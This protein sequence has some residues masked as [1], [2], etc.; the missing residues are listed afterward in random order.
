MGSWSYLLSSERNDVMKKLIGVIALLAIVFS[1]GFCYATEGPLFGFIDNVG[2]D[3]EYGKDYMLP[4]SLRGDHALNT[5]KRYSLRA[6]SR[7]LIFSDKWG[8]Q[9]EFKYSAHKGD[10]VPDHG[11]DAGW[12]ELGFNL[13]LIR[14]FYNDLFYIGFLAGL[15]YVDDLPEFERRDWPD[16][17][18]ESNVGRSHYLGT[19]GPMVGRN[20][21]FGDTPW[22]LKTEMRF[23][24]TSDPFRTDMGKNFIS[25]I[26]GFSYNF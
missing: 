15:S 20:W 3:F 6:E 10:E 8:V 7:N 18:L 16:R 21:G 2:V 26:M 9:F 23:T 22:S 17:C 1:S 13:A 14:H 24:H 4:D 12:K 19:W 5:V 11:Q 25:A